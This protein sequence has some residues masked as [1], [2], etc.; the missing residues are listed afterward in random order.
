MGGINCAAD[1]RSM[2]RLES[3][4]GTNSLH[5]QRQTDRGRR[6]ELWQIQT[7]ALLDVK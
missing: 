6:L 1:S 5:Q 3:V 7:E 2:W 4:G